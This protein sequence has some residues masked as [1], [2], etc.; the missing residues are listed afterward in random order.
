VLLNAIATCSCALYSYGV[1]PQSCRAF[2]TSQCGTIDILHPPID[3]RS[4]ERGSS[5]NNVSGRPR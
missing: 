5:Y 1:A 4:F 3:K 2:E